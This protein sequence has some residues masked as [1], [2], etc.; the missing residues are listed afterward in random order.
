MKRAGHLLAEKNGTK[1][2][3]VLLLG[4]LDTVLY[5]E[6]FRREGEQVSLARGS[7]RIR[8]GYATGNVVEYE[9]V[10]ADGSI[11]MVQ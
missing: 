10:A 7:G 9:V 1:G 6:R 2:K 5:G 8:Q 4:H 11:F 3:R